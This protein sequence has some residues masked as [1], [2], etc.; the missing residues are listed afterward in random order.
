MRG[1]PTHSYRIHHDA[2]DVQV[3]CKLDARV[4]HVLSLICSISKMAATVRSLEYDAEKSPLGEAR[5]L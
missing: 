3:E 4:Q 5:L 1:E 2:T